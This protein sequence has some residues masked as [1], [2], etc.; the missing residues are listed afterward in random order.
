MKYHQMDLLLNQDSLRFIMFM[1]HILAIR[2]SPF[3]MGCF[4]NPPR[5]QWPQ[6]WLSSWQ[7]NTELP[8]HL[9]LF[10]L[11]LDLHQAQCWRTGQDGI[12]NSHL[13]NGDGNGR[14]GRRN[15]YKGTN[16]VAQRTDV[17]QH[18]DT[19]QLVI[20]RTTASRWFYLLYANNQGGV[21]L[22]KHSIRSPY[23]CCEV[24]LNTGLCTR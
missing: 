22:N 9:L 23:T 7:R 13:G 12:H 2:G 21:S 14:A 3:S 15:T 10:L 20:R 11:L 18:S 19:R 1:L 16:F 17:W 8:P 6:E 24:R 5:K 4:L